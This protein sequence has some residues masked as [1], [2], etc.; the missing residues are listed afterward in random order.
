MDTAE[1]RDNQDGIQS[2]DRKECVNMYISEPLRLYY[3]IAM[4]Y[5]SIVLY[6]SDIVKKKIKPTVNNDGG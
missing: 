3:S 6:C 1:G 4:Q 2:S 5:I